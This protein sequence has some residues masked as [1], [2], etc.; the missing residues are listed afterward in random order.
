MKVKPT[1][2]RPWPYLLPLILFLSGCGSS[3]S[4]LTFDLSD[5]SLSVDTQGKLTALINKEDGKN[6]LLNTRESWLLSVKVDS[7]VY[8]PQSVVAGDADTYTLHFPDSLSVQIRIEKKA[9]Y[10][11]LEVIDATPADQIDAVIWGPYFTTL[12]GSIGETVGIVQDSVF[13]LGLQG[14]NV[15]TLGGYPWRENDHMPQLDIFSQSDYENMQREEGNGYVLY[16]VEAARPVDGGSALQAFTRNRSTDRVIDNWGHPH[17]VAPA[18][19][20][21]GVVGSKIALFG[22]E[23]AATLDMIGR[24]ELA[25]GLPHP[26]INGTWIKKSPVINSSY[27]IMDFTEATIDECLDYT[28][29]VGFGYLYH[30]HPF[31]TWGHFPLIEAQFPNGYNGMK[32]CVE[33]AEARG[34]GLGTHTLTNFITTDDPYVTPVPDE[35]LAKVGSSRLSQAITK[36]QS[37]IT[38]EDPVFFNQ[39]ENNTLKSVLIGQEIIRYGSVTEA[40]PWKLLDCQ[41]GAF[42]TTPSAHQAG[43]EISKLMDHPYKVFLGNAELNQEIAENIADFMNETGV[44]MLDFDGLEGGHSTGMGNYAK[45]LFVKQWYDRLDNNLKGHFLAGASR[46][47]HYF[48]H[49][50]A[51][52][53]WGEPWYAGFRE[54]Q[55]EYRLRNQKYY[56]R[57]LMPGMLGWFL[58]TPT[59]TVEDV[60]W[61]MARSAGFDAGFSF[62]ASPETFRQNGKSDEILR[63]IKVWERARLAGLFKPQEKEQMQ[64]LSTEFELTPQAQNKY[65]LTPVQSFKFN[66]KKKVR[67]PGE[68]LYSVYEFDNNGAEQPLTMMLTAVNCNV[69]EITVELDNYKKAVLPITLQKGQTIEVKEGQIQLY[70]KEWKVLKTLSNELSEWTI[71][72]GAHKLNVECQFLEAGEDSALKMEVRMKGEVLREVEVG[73]D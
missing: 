33:K 4:D 69:T 61:L 15:K 66:Y 22:V 71:A 56:R 37:E 17:F 54:S 45:S 50:Y 48:W 3:T 67:Q 73:F 26:E 35:R 53:N 30:G 5:W 62:V 2:P 19:E 72:P 23:T 39:M 27:L 57:N 9:D 68:P 25:E 29:K 60:Q 70:D 8:A 12:E 14:L 16:S 28:E 41:R 40:A 58:M 55:T 24:I 34:I 46:P 11:S 10:L 49:I 36:D 65:A 7:T 64:D 42:G 32:Q 59:T 6:H 21:G 31:Q 1:P 43:T 13:T 47:T 63:I 38:I 51:R 44:R 52:M 20:D 18:Y